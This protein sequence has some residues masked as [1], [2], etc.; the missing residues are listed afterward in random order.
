M[1]IWIV[2]DGPEKSGKTMFIKRFMD[3]LMEKNKTYAAV[4]FDASSRYK[5]ITIHDHENSKSNEHIKAF[6]DAG[7]CEA[8]AVKCP[9]WSNKKENDP[10]TAV[11]EVMNSIY[12]SDDEEITG[13]FFEG[14][15]PMNYLSID[16]CI[17]ITQPNSRIVDEIK[18]SGD[19]RDTVGYVLEK[20]RVIIINHHEGDCPEEIKETI[21]QIRRFKKEVIPSWV[22]EKYNIYVAD[23]SNPKDE[24]LKKALLRVKRLIRDCPKRKMMGFGFFLI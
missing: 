18:E 7:A 12:W 20:A 17:F 6:L 13:I 10:Y 15:K 3:S 22:N 5:G 1:K 9:E 4:K 11:E 16:V 23:L 24:G 2:V 8:Y 14:E 21:R 19:L